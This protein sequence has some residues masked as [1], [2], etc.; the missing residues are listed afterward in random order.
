MWDDIL[1][2]FGRVRL[3]KTD[4]DDTMY[5]AL[6][7][8]DECISD[9]DISDESTDDN[10]LDSINQTSISILHITFYIQFYYFIFSSSE[11]THPFLSKLV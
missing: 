9:D 3:G 4:D 6:Y 8:L 2:K 11:I 10:K 5:Y 7:E 1:Y